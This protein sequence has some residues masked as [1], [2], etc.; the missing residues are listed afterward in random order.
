M[1]G[2][3]QLLH[4]HA[5]DGRLVCACVLVDDDRLGEPDVPARWGGLFRMAAQA[6]E[7]ERIGWH[8]ARRSSRQ[9]GVHAI[10]RGVRR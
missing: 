6:G 9:Q 1:Q 2:A 8:E 10:W 4:E 7:I 3:Q 5:A